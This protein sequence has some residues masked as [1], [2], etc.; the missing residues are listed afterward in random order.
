MPSAAVQPKQILKRA[1]SQKEYEFLQEWAPETLK[2]YEVPSQQTVFRPPQAAPVR[3]QGIPTQ[4]HPRLRT[5][6]LYEDWKAHAASSQGENANKEC[7]PSPHAPAQKVDQLPH[8]VSLKAATVAAE[9]PIHCLQSK[10]NV[11]GSQQVCSK[12]NTLQP[13]HYAQTTVSASNRFNTAHAGD[14]KL[15]KSIAD[16]ANVPHES[17]QNSCTSSS[18]STTPEA[19][20]SGQNSE[21]RPAE[22][23]ELHHP[24]ISNLSAGKAPKPVETSKS[25]ETSKPSGESQQKQNLNGL[26]TTA[27]QTLKPTEPIKK[28]VESRQKLRIGSVCYTAPNGTR[29]PRHNDLLKWSIGVKNQHN[30]LVIFLPVFVESPWKG[31]K[32]ILTTCASR[33]W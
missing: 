18:S 31:L 16:P 6:S 28:A 22:F 10:T 26:T 2:N 11:K 32:P 8:P 27:A 23:N 24:R 13:H 17:Q 9:K 25:A 5:S 12:S 33:Y 14:R 15:S 3:E 21:S 29:F 1:P 20:I 30:D 19:S 7:T 4:R